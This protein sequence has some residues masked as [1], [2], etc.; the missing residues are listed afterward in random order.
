[1]REITVREAVKELGLEKESFEKY[2]KMSFGIASISKFYPLN[3]TLKELNEGEYILPIFVVIGLALVI[4]MTSGF[5]A[6]F[7][8][9]GMN[10]LVGKKLVNLLK[11]YCERNNIE[12]EIDDNKRDLLYVRNK[13][14]DIARIEG[15]ETV[16]MREEAVNLD[17]NQRKLDKGKLKWIVIGVVV[18][19]SLL[20]LGSDPEIANTKD[21][22]VVPGYDMTI[23]EFV[24]EVEEE[25]SWRTGKKAVT[26]WEVLEDD[27]GKSV[28]IA[29]YDSK[30]KEI[31]ETA[32]FMVMSE[33][34]EVVYSRSVGIINGTPFRY[35]DYINYL[36]VNIL[37]DKNLEDAS[38]SL[39]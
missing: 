20:G 34:D 12:L 21:A 9:V 27:K 2:H 13:M 15:G 11:Q 26:E 18:F 38:F 16:E 25:I 22:Q 29:L 31:M 3:K 24:D 14:L 4:F 6:P 39:Y 28:K 23:E 17:G 30:A 36:A 37:G 8:L 5:V 35:A 33:E 19:I 10:Y 1:M 32:I 7:V